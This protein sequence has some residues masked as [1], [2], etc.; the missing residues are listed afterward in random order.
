M[1]EGLLRQDFCRLRPE[2]LVFD[3]LGERQTAQP[4]WFPISIDLSK[5]PETAKFVDLDLNF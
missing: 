4:K 3:L 1:T 5:I 2:K